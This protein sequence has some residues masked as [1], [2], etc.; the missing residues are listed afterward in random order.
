VKSARAAA[1]Q[2]GAMSAAA[3]LSLRPLCSTFDAPG[4]ARLVSAAGAVAALAACGLALRAAVAGRGAD[5]LHANGL[6]A[7]DSAGAQ[8]PGARRLSFAASG[9]AVACVALALLF[10]LREAGQGANPALFWLAGAAAVALAAWARVRLRATL[11]RARFF[12]A[13]GLGTMLAV[14]SALGPSGRAD[15]PVA[16]LTGPQRFEPGPGVNVVLAVGALLLG[17]GHPDAELPAL[18][19]LFAP[20]STAVEPRTP[21]FRHLAALAASLFAG[22]LVL[23]ARALKA[24]P[25]GAAIVAALLSGSAG[26]CV[27]ALLAGPAHRA[28]ALDGPALWLLSGAAALFSPAADN[29]SKAAL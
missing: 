16:P 22:L 9:L 19:G 11:I 20:S 28:F 17:E 21:W 29:E 8:E 18:V 12:W 7:N 27:A 15:A 2:C 5:V 3:L 6:H 10:R 13:L 1:A 25:R 14:V 23:A 24:G 4:A 26:L